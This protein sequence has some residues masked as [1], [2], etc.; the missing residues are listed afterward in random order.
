MYFNLSD[1]LESVVRA[2]VLRGDFASEDEM[3]AAILR[4]YLRRQQSQTPQD[5]VTVSNSVSAPAPSPKRKPLWERAADLRKS[6]PDE[7]WEK[8]PADGARQLDHYIYGSPKR[9]TS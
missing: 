9:P 5:A 4:D 7:E 8:L 6:I 3:V 1:D 2:A